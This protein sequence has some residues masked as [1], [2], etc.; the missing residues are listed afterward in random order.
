MTEPRFF[1]EPSAL[2]VETVLALTGARA[3]EGVDPNLSILGIAPLERARPGDLTFLDNPKYIEALATTAG[4]ACLVAPK[5]SS[6]VP[7]H[8]AA[9]ITPEPYKAFAKVLGRMFPEALRPTSAFAAK[10]VAPG[11][12]VHPQARLEDGVTIDPGAVVGPRAEIGSGTVIGPGAVIG[13]EVRIGRDCSIGANASVQHS[14]IGNRVII[15]PG[16]CIGQDGFGFAMGPGGHLKVPQLGRVIVQDDVEIGANSTIDR[17]ANRDTVVGE[18]TKID[19]L[20]QIAHNVV[21]GRHCVIVAQVGI[22]GSV[23]LEDYVVLGGKVGVVGHVRIG[24]GA[25]IAGTS[26]VASDVPAGARWGGT[27]AKPIKEYFRELTLVQ[28]LARKPRQSGS[29]NQVSDHEA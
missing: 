24:M 11:A 6:R 14:L 13:P 12:S 22:A 28:N 10:G 17:G 15:H 29:E 9:L 7:S 5:F 8:V 18:G 27:P 21:I 26:N 19:N 23:T 4:S 16:V 20:V 1:A 25:Q 3:A 2:T